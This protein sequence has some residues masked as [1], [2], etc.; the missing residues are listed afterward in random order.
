MRKYLFKSAFFLAVM[1]VSI[2]AFSQN[3]IQNPGF[4]SDKT[5]WSGFW[6]KEGTGSAT[7]VTNPVHSGVK[8]IKIDYPGTQDWAFTSADKL[9]VVTGSTYDM[10]CWTLI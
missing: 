6:S 4:E 5:N 2:S 10:Y 3:L 7:I 8:A 9:P 1:L